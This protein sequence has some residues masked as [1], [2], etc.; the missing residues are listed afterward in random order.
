ML[1]RLEIFFKLSGNKDNVV[2]FSF[3]HNQSY[4]DVSL[5]G[6]PKLVVPEHG[7]ISTVQTNFGILVTYECNSGYR[8]NGS[9]TT[10]CV[11]GGM[12]SGKSPKCQGIF[13]NHLVILH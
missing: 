7:S 3:A 8:L 12:W 6:C 5:V 13:L 11:S 1:L 2:F 4:F 10:T 9:A